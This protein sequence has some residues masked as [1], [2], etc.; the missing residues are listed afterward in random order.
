MI[1]IIDYGVGNLESIRRAVEHLGYP[2]SLCTTPRELAEADAV[3]LP[4][5]G[6][7]DAAMEVLADGLAGELGRR[8]SAG[9]PVLGICLGLQLLFSSSAE[10]K[11]PGLGLLPGRVVRLPGG[12]RVP[13]L[14][15]NRVEW[16][17][18]TQQ[19]PA[20]YYFAHSY[21]PVTGPECVL[22]RTHYG[23]EFAAAVG[24]GRLLGV[25]FHPEKSGSAGLELLGD[26]LAGRMPPCC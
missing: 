13:H 17:P 11:R 18:S 14:G 2:A 25:Q 24:C 16:D 1:A 5:V 26:F 3:I 9:T 4:G 23:V 19:T 7:F 8:V 6:A 22:G 20:Y 12:V 21:Y 10:G 15:W